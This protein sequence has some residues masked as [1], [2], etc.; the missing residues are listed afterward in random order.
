H[1]SGFRNRSGRKARIPPG[2][3]PTICRS[4]SFCGL[5]HA[6]RKAGT[7]FAHVRPE[8][9]PCEIGAEGVMQVRWRPAL[10]MAVIAGSTAGGCCHPRTGVSEPETQYTAPEDEPEFAAAANLL[11]GGTAQTAPLATRIGRHSWPSTDNGYSSIEW[12]G[13]R[14][15]YYDYQ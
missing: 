12:T 2:G 3:A 4:I 11:F 1:H 15:I 10:L 6:S 14:E 7:V 9:A 5:V 8:A 13:F